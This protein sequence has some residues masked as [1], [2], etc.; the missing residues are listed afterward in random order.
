MVFRYILDYTIIGYLLSENIN[1]HEIAKMGFESF[2]GKCNKNHYI[3][4]VYCKL[5]E[6]G[7]DMYFLH[8][9]DVIKEIIETLNNTLAF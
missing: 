2:Y 6:N 3:D 4:I 1:S 8:V 9:E 7:N 5:N